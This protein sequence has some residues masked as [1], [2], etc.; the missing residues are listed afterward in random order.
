MSPESVAAAAAR[1][2][3]IVSDDT[4]ILACKQMLD[5][6]ALYSASELFRIRRKLKN[7]DVEACTYLIEHN[8]HIRKH[9][10]KDRVGSTSSDRSEAAQ[11]RP[12][13][14]KSRNDAN[15]SKTSISKCTRPAV[16]FALGIAER[17]PDGKVTRPVLNDVLHTAL[18]DST[19]SDE[20]HQQMRS[21]L[22][23]EIQ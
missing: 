8:D 22:T 14:K 10:G 19:L 21:A 13:K 17:M 20:Q 9:S 7:A 23:L 1:A 11:H 6:A 4:C 16:E 12:L 5:S 2:R 18:L 15:M 3:N